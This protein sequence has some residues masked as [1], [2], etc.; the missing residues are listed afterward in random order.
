MQI[1]ASGTYLLTM[2][3]YENSKPMEIDM[4][5]NGPAK[6]KVNNAAMFPSS[7]SLYDKSIMGSN[8]YL[9]SRKGSVSYRSS[10]HGSISH[11]GSVQGSVSHLG[12]VRSTILLPTPIFGSMISINSRR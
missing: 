9:G 7:P 4:D 10:V 1:L 6:S 2:Y 3:K 12:S 11:I 8:G 5:L